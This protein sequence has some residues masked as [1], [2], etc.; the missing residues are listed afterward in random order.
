MNAKLRP[1]KERIHLQPDP[2]CCHLHV[3]LSFCETEGNDYTLAHG[4]CFIS[5]TELVESRKKGNSRSSPLGLSIYIFFL[6]D[7]APHAVHVFETGSAGEKKAHIFSQ[8]R[9]H[10]CVSV[11]VP[12]YNGICSADLS[13]VQA[14]LSRPTLGPE[15]QRGEDAQQR[16]WG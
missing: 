12:K 2:P 8:S 11:S 16:E 9:C 7:W 3:P 1:L 6:V 5:L 15:E 4:A 13:C 10:Y 14:T